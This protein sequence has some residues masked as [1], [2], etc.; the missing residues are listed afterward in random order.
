MNLSTVGINFVSGSQIKDLRLVASNIY[1]A[2]RRAFQA[3]MVL[4]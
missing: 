1:R 2:E 4:K 3:E